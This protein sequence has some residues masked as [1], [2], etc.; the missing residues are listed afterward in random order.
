[1]DGMVLAAEMAADPQLATVPIIMLTPWSHGAP[2]AARAREAGARTCLAR[3]VR[4]SRL[5]DALAAAVVEPGDV[6]GST[7]SRVSSRGEPPLSSVH[8]VQ[9]NVLVA[10]DNHVNQR[11]IVRMLEKAGHRV[12]VARTGREAVQAVGRGAYDLVL[13]DCLMPEMDGFEATRAI[14]AGETESGRHLP[15]V[16]LTANAMQGDRDQCLAAGMDD[17]LTKPILKEALDAVLERAVAKS[18]GRT[19]TR[20][21]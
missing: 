2:A 21:R 16:A 6:T 7:A 10:E 17:Y 3:P 14:R 12:E 11:L 1:M 8:P 4:P 19:S 18:T 5:L 15:I 9:L 13:M 20:W